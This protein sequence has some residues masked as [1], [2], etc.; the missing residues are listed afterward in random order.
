MGKFL[1]TISKKLPKR[2]RFRLPKFLILI[3]LVTSLAFLGFFGVGKLGA[4]YAMSKIEPIFLLKDGKFLLLFQNNAEIRSSGGFIGS[5]A[6]VDIKNLEIQ[7]LD[8]NTNILKLDRSYSEKV[9][10]EGGDLILAPEPLAKFLKNKPWTLR[11]ANYDASFPDASQDISKF[12]N[13]ETGGKV[14]GIIA[15]NAQVMVDLLKLTGPIS[16]DKYGVTVTA[17]NFYDTTQYEIEKD[18]FQNPENWVI[19]EPKTFLKDLYPEII[20]RA[21]NNKIALAKLLK[22]ELDQKEVL[23]NFVDPTKEQIAIEHNWAG[24]IPA[25]QEL[26][27]LFNTADS[28]DYLY[29][30]SNSY[31]GD[32]S[33]IKMKESID[34]KVTLNEQGNLQAGLKLTRIH[35]GSYTWPDGPNDTWIRVLVPEGSLLLNAKLNEQD[36]RN[37]VI[38]GTEAEKTFFGYQNFTNPGQVSI[39]EFNYVLPVKT[40]AYHL[41]VQKQPGVIGEQIN[42]YYL[43]QILY[44]GILDEDK[45]FCYN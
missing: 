45:K 12:Y 2:R 20:S 39:L 19:N 4:D 16:L 35:T 3:L 36:I 27:D 15:L 29:I 31:S 17:D 21:F 22:K 42:V 25:N 32:K 13:L 14:D 28:A 1:D 38:L 10:Q 18:Y 30:N 33:S 37:N 9:Q 44:D 7:S 5:Y 24:K 40:D 6:V 26:K 41:L 43:G 34:Y 23:L 8:F 11:D